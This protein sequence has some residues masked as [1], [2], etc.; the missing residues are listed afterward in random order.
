MRRRSGPRTA[1]AA[2]ALAVLACGPALPARAA[3]PLDLYYERTLMSAAGARCGLFT[4]ELASA[5]EAAAAQA[6]SAALRGGVTSA[7]LDGA[8]SRA[9]IVAGATPCASKDLATAAGRVRS[10]FEGYSRFMRLDLPGDVAAWRAE[11]RAPS[12]SAGWRL[13]QASS[14]S[15]APLIFGLAGRQGEAPQLLAVTDVGP[16]PEPYAARLIVRDPARAPSPYLGVLKV[17]SSAAI[18]LSSRTPPRWAT[19]AFTADTR[20]DASRWLLPAGAKS[21][22]FFRL[23]AAAV[24]ALAALDPREAVTVELLYPGASGDVAR[25]AYVEVGD[26]AAGRAFISLGR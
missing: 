7:Q 13:S 18:P 16:G 21:A 19:R 1:K 15:G 6:R 25:Q 22:V 24:D 12:D 14:I 8:R 26:F 10:A 17:S 23:P 9:G 20:G 3:A 4:P 11:R 2:I 5:L